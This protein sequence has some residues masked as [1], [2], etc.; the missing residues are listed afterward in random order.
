[1]PLPI[2]WQQH[3]QR[4][5]GRIGSATGTTGIPHVNN[6][7]GRVQ[8]S[9]DGKQEDTRELNKAGRTRGKEET[10]P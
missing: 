5:L 7:D 9:R 8:T 10:E 3:R 6:V 2:G 4:V 1:M